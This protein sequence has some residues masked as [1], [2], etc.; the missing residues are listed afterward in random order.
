MSQKK[1]DLSSVSQAD[2]SAQKSFLNV[3]QGDIFIPSLSYKESNLR[4][5]KREDNEINNEQTLYLFELFKRRWALI[6]LATLGITTGVAAWTFQQAPIYQGKFMLLLEKP[7]ESQPPSGQLATGLDGRNANTNVD[8]S[9]EISILGSASVLS[10]ILAEISKNY[11]DIYNDIDLQNLDNLDIKQLDNTKIIEVSFRHPDPDK[12]NYVLNILASK[13][14]EYGVNSGEK[15]VGE[16]LKFVRNQIP[17]L[18][19]NINN[20]Q[21]KIE[22]LRKDYKFIEPQV[23]ATELT[24][25]LVVTEKE[26][27][28]TQI[29]ITEAE[30]AYNSIQQQLKLSPE[31]AIALR[32][33]TESPKYQSLLQQ[34]QEIEVELANQSAIFTDISPQIMTL[35]EKKEN[36]LKLIAEEKAKFTLKNQNPNSQNQGEVVTEKTSNRIVLPN[37]MRDKLT[38]DLIKKRDEIKVL[39]SKKESLE[40]VL[41]NLNQRIAELPT[42]TRE[43]N[44]LQRELTT[45]TE[46]L[47]R[48]LETREKLEL[49]NV[50]NN[51][52]W[53]IISPPQ[54][55]EK[56]ISPLPIYNILF[57]LFGGLGFSTILASLIDKSD[58]SIYDVKKLKTLTKLPLLTEIPFDKNIKLSSKRQN[59]SNLPSFFTVNNG[60]NSLTQEEEYL[61]PLTLKA[62]SNLYANIN[63][64]TEESQSKSIVISSVIPSSGK[65]TICFNLA[66]I[67]AKMEQKV[68]L[69]DTNFQLPQLHR[70]AKVENNQGLSH[71]LKGEISWQDSIQTPSQWDNL[72]LITAGHVF[73]DPSSLIYGAKM[74]KMMEEIQASQQFDLIIYDSPSLLNLSDAKIIASHTHGLILVVKI[75]KTK[76]YELKQVYEQIKV[77]NTRIL[78]MVANEV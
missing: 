28:A 29:Q 72:F 16:A 47:K 43:Y 25:Q 4:R 65:S 13:Y 2:L 41:N 21:T 32:D 37:K 60:E 56:P 71:I 46:S 57:G 48:F 8:Y 69:I 76:D 15:N 5:Q 38:E 44:N 6:V 35:K 11:P 64:L 77:T 49:D 14:L 24:K 9:T 74:S 67:V 22:K 27:F 45:T 58:N 17:I 30:S 55:G 1:S 52:N 73:S 19:K 33:L 75:G 50:Q 68:L 23:Q 12:I 63:L 51:L 20:L 54:V 78:G 34:L 62:L 39:K 26:F 36:I 66:K 7:M 59:T 40:K 3:E 31:E 18:E 10:P 42:V 53:Q 61:S 70:L